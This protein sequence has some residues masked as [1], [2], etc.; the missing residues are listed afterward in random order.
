VVVAEVPLERLGLEVGRQAGARA[1]GADVAGHPPEGDGELGAE[2][3]RLRVEGEVVG[4][5]GEL[6]EGEG[7]AAFSRRP[8]RRRRG[9]NTRLD[10][11]RVV[12]FRRGLKSDYD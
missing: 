8:G 10:G 7:R 12:A 9:A 11:L 2:D 6:G 1:H 3:E 4:E 5:E